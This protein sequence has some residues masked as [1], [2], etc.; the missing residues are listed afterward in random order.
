[1]PLVRE[2]Q[3]ECSGNHN[4]ETTKFVYQVYLKVVEQFSEIALTFN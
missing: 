1:M 4:G 2:W 3:R